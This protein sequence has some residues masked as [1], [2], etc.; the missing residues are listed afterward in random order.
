LT[1]II[2]VENLYYRYRDGT[3]ALRGL[4]FFIPQDKRVA[5]LGPNGA[6]KSTLLLHLNGLYLPQKG[7][8]CVLGREINPRTE[9]WVKSKVGLVF[10]DPDDQVFSATVKDDVAFGPLNMDLP[11]HEVER[12]VSDS[13]QAVQME[14]YSNKPP[15]HLSHGQKK[16][17]AI[18][19]V[20]AMQP[21]VILFDEPTSY[22]DPKSKINLIKILNQLHRQGTTI[23]IA[24]HDVDL[25]AEWADH[26]I[27]I[28]EG[29]TLAQGG[30][31]LLTDEDLI[32]KANL[33]FPTVV[34]IFRQLPGV[35]RNFLPLNVNEAVTVLKTIVTIQVGTEGQR[36]KGAK[37]NENV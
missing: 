7:K 26:I 27:I 24:T 12:R 31:C 23:V 37:G 19:G 29:Q 18:A 4:S 3:E 5:L 6:G 1:N 21:K 28:K 25:A 20:L 9:R 33:C 17:V 36:H 15:Y 32:E 8:V 34:Q 22:L 2:E 30:T 16:R 14:K 10:Q 35:K 11:E 13:L